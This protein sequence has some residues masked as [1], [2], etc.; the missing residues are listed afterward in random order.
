M[1]KL[2]IAIEKVAIENNYSIVLDAAVGAIGYA[3][4]KLDITDLIIEE[5]EKTFETEEEN[6]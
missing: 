5:I 3:K 2:R 6:K 4:S 1:D